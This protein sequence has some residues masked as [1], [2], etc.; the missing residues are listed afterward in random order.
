MAE[1]CDIAIETR[2][3]KNGTIVSSGHTD[4][5]DGKSRQLGGV[6]AERFAYSEAG[7]HWRCAV[8]IG[9]QVIKGSPVG[10]LNGVA[11][12]AP[13]DGIVRGVVRDGTD[14]PPRVK[15][16]E[17]DPR[18]SDACWTGMDERGRAIAQATLN[19]IG[20]QRAR[21]LRAAAFA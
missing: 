14:V 11:V 5:A 2:P 17:I 10:F 3:V 8:E 19:A 16:F 9:M 13:F 12:N 20:S 15:L 4:P 21:Q 18:G 7:G 6:G 1:N